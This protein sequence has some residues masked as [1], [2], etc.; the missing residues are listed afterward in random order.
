MMRHLYSKLLSEEHRVRGG[1]K[2]KTSKEIEI[3]VYAI[4]YEDI[5][6]VFRWQYE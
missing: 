4:G 2:L 5:G 3:T 6:F 1:A